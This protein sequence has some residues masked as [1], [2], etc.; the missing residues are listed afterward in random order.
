MNFSRNT[1]GQHAEM[2]P[3]M[4]SSIRRKVSV[5][6]WSSQL[7]FSAFSTLCLIFF[8]CD[9]IENKSF[10][11]FLLK[12]SSDYFPR[13]KEWPRLVWFYCFFGDVLR[14]RKDEKRFHSS[15]LFFTLV[16]FSA[17]VKMTKGLHC[18]LLHFWYVVK[19][20]KIQVVLGSWKDSK[21]YPCWNPTFILTKFL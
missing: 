14:T 19:D 18:M 1:F 13:R 15:G 2:I 5:Q 11:T 6:C 8:G 10:R 7:Y 12:R 4:S 17:V 16:S 20:C 21:M 3:G 9:L